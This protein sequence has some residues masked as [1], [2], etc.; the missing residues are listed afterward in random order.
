VP[1]AIWKL[2]PRKVIA[3]TTTITPLESVIPVRTPVIIPIKENTPKLSIIIFR[4]SNFFFIYY[5]ILY[6]MLKKNITF[7][8]GDNK[9][10]NLIDEN[11]QKYIT[12]SVSQYI[13]PGFI[14]LK[15]DIIICARKGRR[16]S[17]MM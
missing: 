14:D 12:R 17:L 5:E 4:S 13:E 1:T 3:G 2:Y 8:D 6:G 9:K 10:Y 11:N 16:I 15:L 7:F